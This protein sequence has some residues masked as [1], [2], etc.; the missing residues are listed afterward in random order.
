MNAQFYVIPFDM[1]ALMQKREHARCSLQQSIAQHLHLII[2]TAFGELPADQNFGCSIW[3]YDFDNITSEHKL[4]ELIKQS[5]FTSIQEYENRLNNVRIELQVRQEELSDN[6]KGKRV[7]K[8]FDITVR[9]VLSATN[10]NFIYSDI[11]FTGPLSYQ[12]L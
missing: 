10:E 2:T 1:E 8:R 7:K 4:K 6:I 9:A 3:E 11:F 5:L 12:S